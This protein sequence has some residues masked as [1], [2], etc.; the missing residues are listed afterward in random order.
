MDCVYSTLFVFG[1]P[2]A[3]LAYMNYTE[4][5]FTICWPWYTLPWN[6]SN[7]ADKVD[8]CHPEFPQPVVVLPLILWSPPPYPLEFT[9]KH[10]VFLPLWTC[11]YLVFLYTESHSTWPLL[12]Q[13]WLFWNS[14]CTADI[15]ATHLALLYTSQSLLPAHLSMNLWVFS[16]SGLLWMKLLRTFLNKFIYI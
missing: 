15:N 14:L 4:L 7:R 3:K 8:V 13:R 16:S 6:H 10:H 12:D 5:N 11:E 9:D 1:F 2:E